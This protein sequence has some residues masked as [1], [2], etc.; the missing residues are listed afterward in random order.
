MDVRE[1][2]E[3]DMEAIATI[4]DVPTGMV[5]NLIHDRTVRVAMVDTEQ[6]G[7]DPNVDVDVQEGEQLTGM[8]SFDVRD[9][10]VHVTQLAGTESAC[11][12]LLS[13]PLSFAQAENLP[14]EVVVSTDESDK[15]TILERVGF[16][17]A[18]PGPDFNGSETRR[19]EH[20]P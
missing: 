7:T 2:K 19:F 4:A 14:V 8:V 11:E 6:T 16:E 13:E 5:R 9:G 18:G 10:R 17:E 20:R 1:A 3:Q 12:T 15:Q